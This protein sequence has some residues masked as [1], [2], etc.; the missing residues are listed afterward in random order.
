MLLEQ[1]CQYSVHHIDEDIDRLKID[2]LIAIFLY[3]K[4]FEI[5]KRL[6]PILI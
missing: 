2:V 3:N 1:I 4:L 6:V 5:I